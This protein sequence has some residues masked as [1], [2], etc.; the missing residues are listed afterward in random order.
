M[1]G[2]ANGGAELRDQRVDAAFTVGLGGPVRLAAGLK[3][4]ALDQAILEHLHGPREG[5]DLIVPVCRGNGDV[6]VAL[7]QPSR[8]FGQL[9]DGASDVPDHEPERQAHGPDGGQEPGDRHHQIVAHL[10]QQFGA[11]ETDRE[12]AQILVA[13]RDDGNGV[14]GGIADIDLELAIE[15]LRRVVAE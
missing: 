15:T 13:F 9:H 3:G 5:A 2:V 8:G 12:E 11:R 10:R 6:E 7:R 1:Q 14:E 4:G